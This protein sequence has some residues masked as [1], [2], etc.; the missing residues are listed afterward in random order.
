[1]SPGLHV[2]VAVVSFRPQ[3]AHGLRQ[4]A[5]LSSQ[6]P[7]PTSYSRHWFAIHRAVWNISNCRRSKLP[8]THICAMA[9]GLPPLHP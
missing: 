6:P 3:A 7:G 5:G 8:C 2:G 4:Q 9:T 1:M